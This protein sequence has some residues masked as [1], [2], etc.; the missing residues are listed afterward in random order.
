MTREEVKQILMIM[1]TSYANFKVENK[2]QTVDVWTMLLADYPFEQMK[3]ALLTY[4]QTS[5]SAFAPSISELIAMTRKPVE[6]TQMDEVTAW[7]Q[8]RKGISRGIYYAQEEFDKMA[9]EVQRAVGEPSQLSEWAK[10][11]SD[12]IDSVVQSNFKK[13]FETMQKRQAEIDSMPAEI[14]TMIAE[15]NVQK[16]VDKHLAIV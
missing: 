1:E 10:M 7:R 13:R 2:T 4:I 8:V 5:G 9:P 14:R 12:V 3:L 6:L 15:K 16:V 11:P